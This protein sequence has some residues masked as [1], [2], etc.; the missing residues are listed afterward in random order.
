MANIDEINY[1]KLLDNILNNGNKKADRTGVGTLSLFGTQLRFS[2]K[3]NTI[4]LLT[5]KRVFHRGIIEELLFFIR[6]ETNSKKLEEKNVNIWKGNTSREFLDSRGLNHY[7]EGEM[8]PMYGNKW[9]DFHGEDQL[10]NALNLIKNDPN[11]RRIMITA[12]DPSASKLCVL[13]PCHMFFQFYVIDNTLSCQFYMRSI[14]CFLGLPFNIASYAILT[15]L[16]A[17]AAGLEVGELIYSG[18]DT[19]IYNTHTGQVKEQISREPFDFPTL[20]INKDVNSIN[21]ME[22]LVF[23][24]F[25]IKNYKYHPAIKAEMAI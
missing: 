7:K 17:K 24:D 8:G 25:E 6:G 19:H 18:G 15:H 22:N 3:N 12:Y 13:D 9:R 21:D 10:K 23:E 5:S 20:Q 11:S 16:T 1:L 4:P 14:D 2:L